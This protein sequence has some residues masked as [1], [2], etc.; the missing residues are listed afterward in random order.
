MIAI[1][2]TRLITEQREA[3]E[4]QTATAEVLQ[5]IN[6]SP[7][8]LAP[9]FE[10]MLDKALRLCDANFG[11]LITFDG[12]GFR[13]AAWQGFPPEPDRPVATR[14]TPGMALHRLIHG[15]EVVH[16]PDITA[17]EVY[18]SGNPTRRRLA[19][20][21]GGRT[22]IWVALKRDTALLGAAVIYRTEV[23]P[24]TE[25]QIAVLKNFADQAVI[26]MEN[27]RLI[28]EQQEALAQQTATA[29]VLQVIN[30]SPGNLAPVFDAILEKA[31]RLCEAAF[32]MFNTYDGTSFRTVV[33]RGVPSAFAAFRAQHPPIPR[34]GSPFGR[35]VETKRPVH[36]VDWLEE[37][38]YKA[39]T[40]GGR[41]IAELGGARTVLNVPLVKDAAVLGMISFYRREVR[42]F[43]DQEVALLENFA[44]HAV[45]AMENARLLVEQREALERQTATTEIL[46]VINANPGTLTPVF[47]VILEKAAHMRLCDAAFG[48]LYVTSST[49]SASSL[50]PCNLRV[51]AT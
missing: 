2:N 33:T 42:A 49:E 22:A 32:G 15:E 50:S 12:V 13:A 47:D 48:S 39:G 9:V 24:F 26:A 5:V 11:Q 4:Q 51:A 35:A 46:Q 6:A 29:E 18:R 34:V 8:N 43:S 28:A 30:A 27:A 1:E 16:V 20:E 21:F 7:G 36:V 38:I 31:M 14:P 3:L 19:D 37:P 25:K 17:D 10:V 41:A 23:R 44:A 40:P 45:I